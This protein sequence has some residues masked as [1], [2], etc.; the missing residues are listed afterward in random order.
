MVTATVVKICYIREKTANRRQE[1][2]DILSHEQLRSSTR[3]LR[4]YIRGRFLPFQCKC[5]WLVLELALISPIQVSRT[6]S[7]SKST[8]SAIYVTDFLA[9]KV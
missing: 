6:V 8:I 1:R 9:K 5:D 2:S 4:T 3:Q 7:P